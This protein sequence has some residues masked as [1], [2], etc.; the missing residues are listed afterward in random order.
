M[1][2]VTSSTGPEARLWALLLGVMLLLGG[3]ASVEFEDTADRLPWTPR[4]VAGASGSV[5]GTV[6]WGGR[7]VAIE[8]L[9]DGTE[10]QVLALPLNSGN[11]P[12]VDASSVGRFVAWYPGF[13]EPEDYAPGRYVSLA[14]RLEGR[15]EGSVGDTAILLPYVRTAQVHLWPRDLGLWNNRWSVGVGVGIDL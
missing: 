13:L 2:F 1:R 3:C 10:F 7:I 9:S 4:D 6:V 8:N 11:V 12:D 14:G 15:V 5:S